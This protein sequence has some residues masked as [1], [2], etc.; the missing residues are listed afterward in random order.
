MLYPDDGNIENL[1]PARAKA[2]TESGEL[3]RPIIRRRAIDCGGNPEITDRRVEHR[4]GRRDRD[5]PRAN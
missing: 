1:D 4:G 2:T 5:L 3:E